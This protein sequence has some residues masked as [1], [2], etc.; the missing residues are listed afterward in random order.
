MGGIQSV[1][2]RALLFFSL[3][4]LSQIFGQVTYAYFALILHVGV[5]YP[6]IGDI[7]YFSSIPLYILGIY[8][9]AKAAGVVITPKLFIQRPKAIIIPT[10]L[11]LVG[12]YLFLKEYSFDWSSPLR[13]FL[14]FAYPLGD[15]IYVSLAILTYILSRKALGGV[16]K[17]RILFI[18]FALVFQFITDYTFLYQSSR[19]IWSGG[20][21]NDYMYLLTY[22][23]MTLALLQFKTVH[24]QLRSKR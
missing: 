2:G 13:V 23:L 11:L 6:S 17:P 10:V 1:M 18:L 20:G 21:M 15:A 22:F 12:Y 24:D 4:L 8:N 16:M 14:D 9:L 3:S 5:P 19:G 7:G